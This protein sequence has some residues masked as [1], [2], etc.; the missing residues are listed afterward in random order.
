MKK[1]KFQEVYQK[2]KLLVDNFFLGKLLKTI[3]KFKILIDFCSFMQR[4]NTEV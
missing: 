1:K 2:N 4:E 3:S